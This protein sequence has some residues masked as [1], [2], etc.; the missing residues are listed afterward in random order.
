MA[1]A[2]YKF[3]FHND[4][5]NARRVFDDPS[6]NRK[7]RVRRLSLAVIIVA[8]AWLILFLNETLPLSRVAEEVRVWWQLRQLQSVDLKDDSV[9]QNADLSPSLRMAANA[10]SLHKDQCAGPLAQADMSGQS[11]APVRVFGHI[12]T[13]LE[14]APLSLER[15]CGTLN[16]VV[17][18]WITI[19]SSDDRPVVEVAVADVRKPV[20]EHLGNTT[21]APELMPSVLLETGNDTAKFLKDLGT[22]ELARGIASGLVDAA[23]SLSATGI[24]LDF[25]QLSGPQLLSL[26]SFF[27][28]ASSSIEDKGL[29]SCAVFSVGQDVW[30]KR[31]ITDLFDNI[32]LKAFRQPWTGSPPGPLA[33]STWFLDTARRAIASVGRDRLTIALGSFAVDWTARQPLPQTL[34]FAEA[35]TRVDKANEG[36]TF[37]PASGNTFASYQDQNGNNHKLWLLDSASVF[38]QTEMLKELGLRNIGVWSLGQEDPGVWDVLQNGSTDRQYLAESLSR[39]RFTDY[40]SYRGEGPF[41]RVLTPPVVGQRRVSFDP[42]GARVADVEYQRL[43]RPYVLER[44][45]A[46]KFN[47]LVL[48][49]DDGPHPEYTT[50]ILDILKDTGTVGSF[51]VVGSRVLAEP[52]LA[53]R[54]IDEGHEIGSHTFSHPRMDLISNTRAD[55]EHGMS[56]KL[57]SSYTG[58][59]AVLYREPFMRA[60]GP[61]EAGRVRSLQNVQDAGNIIAGMDI[62][63]KDWE[64]WTAD[65]IAQ[66][67]I[68]E[69]E[70]GSGNVI[71]LHDA[72]KDRSATVEAL[73]TII[74]ELTERGYEFTSLAGLLGLNR[75][76]LMPV[77][78][79]P[80]QLF[81]K[82]SF[83]AISVTWG[84]VE[85]VF[86]VALGIGVFRTLFIF[87]LA[88]GRKRER[89]IETGYR[90]KVSVVIPAHNEQAVIVKCVERVLASDYQ[91]FDVMI[92]DDGSQDET[93]NE[94]LRFQHDPRVRIFSHLNRGKWGALNAALSYTD[95]DLVVCVDADT[96]IRPDAI[97]Y[98][99]HRFED[100]KVGA[101]AGKVTVGNRN[102]LLAKLQALEYVTAQNF[103]RRAYDRVNGIMVVPGAI[104]AWRVDAICEAGLFCNDTLTEDADMTLAI[105]RAG[106]RVTHEE[107][108]IGYTEAPEKVGQL[109][110]QRLRWSLGMFQCAWKHKGAIRQGK[111]I[112]LLTIPDMLVFGYLF[113]LLAP[114]ADIFVMIL[115]Y[116]LFAGT[117]SGEVGASVSN[118]PVHMILAYFALPLLDLFVAGYALKRDDQESLGLLWLFP[119][120][121]FF[122]RQLLYFSVYRSLLRALTGTLAN[123]GRMK[124][125]GMSYMRQRV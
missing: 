22:P 69:V 27:Q 94:V 103:D 48:T 14:W 99:V 102:K 59:S 50:A 5:S 101:V 28:I 53:R 54:I 110:A 97:R 72:G 89:P 66:Y 68:D 78:D 20:E 104:G 71:L 16:V 87:V 35:L 2:G 113:P 4:E 32:I 12:P 80:L 100:P 41:L 82:I 122:Y 3:L 111:T 37:S 114:I 76:D 24:C 117:W 52:E 56:D 51:F 6:Q 70:K 11:A 58:R 67:V 63:P 9:R 26:S 23:E 106:Y 84:G 81:H 74:R 91:D 40:I 13:E 86:W 29:V 65:E 108:A 17:P 57:I 46:A 92:V 7:G 119:F 115:I 31:Q 112:G 61:I 121:R 15:S 25:R 90:P 10:S 8:M 36:L 75:A 83:Q 85:T 64:G 125:T 30:E 39:I 38:N 93:L 47:Q 73:P 62:V 60:G 43:P 42:S 19:V 33:D 77:V 107:M 96:D 55:L 49:F 44:Y 21:S 79:D 95:A 1:K 118:V 45:G 109:L 124:R 116:K 123:W 98:L 34:P 18:D 105:N 88:A 120:Q